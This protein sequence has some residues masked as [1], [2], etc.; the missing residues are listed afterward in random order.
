MIESANQVDLAG[1]FEN[2]N[3]NSYDRT[4]DQADPVVDSGSKL[5]SD[6]KKSD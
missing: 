1:W 4:Y 3:K 6:P 2:N 5:S